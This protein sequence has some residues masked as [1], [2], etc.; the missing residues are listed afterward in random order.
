MRD[1]LAAAR[2]LAAEHGHAGPIDD[3]DL[4]DALRRLRRAIVAARLRQ[5]SRA[6]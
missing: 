2:A 5:D 3:D 4:A 6:P 1:A